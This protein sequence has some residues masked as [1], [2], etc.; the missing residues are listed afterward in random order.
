M[1][2]EFNDPAKIRGELEQVE[3]IKKDD[4]TYA[5][6]TAQSAETKKALAKLTNR[7][8]SFV[9][10]YYR[11]GSQAD[12]VRKSYNVSTDKSAYS[13]AAKLMAKP[14]VREA[15]AFAFSDRWPDADSDMIIRL[16]DIITD[17]ET[18][19]SDAVAAIKELSKLKG[20]YAPAKSQRI[21]ANVNQFKLPGDGDG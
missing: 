4:P 11:G 14:S 8:Q 15:L 6:P 5:E 7:E 3:K 1:S 16:R 21:I 19:N 18:K 13:R 10:A 9:Q 2:N 12:A 17:P 20:L